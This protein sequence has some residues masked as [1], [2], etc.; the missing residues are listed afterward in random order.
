[1]KIHS[2]DLKLKIISQ[3]QTNNGNI[4]IKEYLN[5]KREIFF[6]N[7]ISVCKRKEIFDNGYQMIYFKNKEIKQ[8]Y[9]EEKKFI[10]SENNTAATTFKKGDKVYKFSNGQM[11]KCFESG[12]KNFF[13]L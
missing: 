13:F 2:P 10:F 12:G 7:G 6:N 11:E 4:I 8:I 3:E 1:M 5:H 9:P